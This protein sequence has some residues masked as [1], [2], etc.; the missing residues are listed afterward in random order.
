M[1]LIRIETTLDLSQIK[2]RERYHNAEFLTENIGHSQAVLLAKNAPIT[3][4][5][6]KI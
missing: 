4:V 3:T 1:S 5:F 2:G 6:C